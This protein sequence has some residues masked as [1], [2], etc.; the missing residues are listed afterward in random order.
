[1]HRT[2]PVAAEYV[3]APQSVHSA[4]PV[5]DLYFPATH[6]A[7]VS[8][9]GPVDPALQVQ[10]VKD[11]LP[12]GEFEFDG[13]TLHVEL[14]E[15]PSAV[16]YVPAT[17]SEQVA[18]PVNTLYFPDTQAEQVPP[19]GPENPASQVQFVKSKLPSD[20]LEFD[21]Q[22]LHVVP[23]NVLYCP[24]THPVHGPPSGPVDS[25]LQVQ[26]VKAGS[27]RV[28]EYLPVSHSTQAAAPTVSKYVPAGQSLQAIDSALSLYVPVGQLLQA[29]APA[30]SEY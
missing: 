20:E 23:V 29:V 16:E 8:P 15:A 14:V 10:F 22:S 24:A 1:M 19:S 6:A 25:A 28:A 3:P 26:L 30:N 4:D 2:A 13:Q 9:T 18:V 27:P 12:A 7:H 21:G 17:Q 11:A 5:D